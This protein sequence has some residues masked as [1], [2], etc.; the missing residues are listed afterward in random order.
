MDRLDPAWLDRQYNNRARI[1]EHPQIFARWDKASD[2]AREGMSRRLDI[3]YGD[4]LNE[5]LDVY[6]TTAADAPVLVFIHGGYWRSLDKR[7]FAFVAPS[8]VQAGAM[9]VVPNYALCPAVT[10]EAIALQMVHAV[11]WT[12]RHAALYGGDPRRI[13]VA[14]HSAG[15][16]LA[17]MMLSCDW[18]A[19]ARDLPP[20]LVRRALSISGLYDL[21]PL[22]HTP[23]LQGDLRLTPQAVR[24]ASPAFFPVPAGT[25][26]AAVGA[27]E[28]EEFLRQN[29]LIR[30]RWGAQ[31]VPVCE[32]IPGTNHLDV[33]HEL[34]DPKARLHAMAKELLGLSRG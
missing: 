29:T 24:R 20:D 10:V 14:G 12:W 21:E 19:V 7:S 27:L 5:T 22:R 32:S 4:G 11:A 17:A 28:S 2:L 9:V 13:V 16:H 26:Y 3:A 18:Q 33:V 6:P 23:F 8:F 1:P 25:L 34:V 30:D 15:G 31:A